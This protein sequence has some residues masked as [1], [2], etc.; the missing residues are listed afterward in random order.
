VIDSVNDHLSSV[1]SRVSEIRQRLSHFQPSVQQPPPAASA[2]SPRIDES[3]EGSIQRHAQS[4]GLSPELLKAVIRAE[5]AFNPGAVSSK[6]AMGLMQL[7]PAT[8]RA[9]GVSDPFDPDANIEG[10]ARHLRQQIDRFK[11]LPLALAAYNA[12]PGNVL[13]YNGVPPFLETRSYVNRV[14][15]FLS[16][17][18]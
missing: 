2:G 7:M 11:E 17:D 16:Q 15:G 3:M 13:R 6:G 18:R 5:S 10:G 4:N 14:M 12:G 9:L 1:L 8:A